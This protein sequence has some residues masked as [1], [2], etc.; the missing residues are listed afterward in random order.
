MELDQWIKKYEAKTEPFFIPDGFSLWFEPD[1][2]FFLWR[3]IDKAFCI[4]AFCTNDIRY[5]QQKA[6]DIGKFMGCTFL[7]T[8]TLHN[9]AAFRR[10]TKADLNLA[11]SGVR[12]N[13][14]MYWVFEKTIV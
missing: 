2:G 6:N 1:K 10:L 12:S 5:L 7:S 14:R 11:L 3:K 4:D 9:P 13:G 8:Q